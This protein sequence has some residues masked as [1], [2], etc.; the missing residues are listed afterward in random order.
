M[1]DLVNALRE[2]R[3]ILFVGAG[4]SR[5]LGLPSFDQ[6]IDHLA[7]ELG[8]DPEIFRLFGDYLSLAEYYNLQKRTLGPL[9]SWLDREWHTGIDIASSRIHELMVKL[10]CPLVYTTNYDRWIEIAHAHYGVAYKKVVNVGDMPNVDAS[11]V[12]IVKFHGDFD[13][14]NSIIL[15]ESSYFERLSFESPL[16]IKLRS[17]VLGRAVLFIGYSL[18]DINIRYMLYKLHRQWETS[19]YAKVRPKSYF[20]LSSPNPVHEQI[21]QERGILSFTSQED[22]PGKGLE[23]FLR[24]LVSRAF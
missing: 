16:D 22:D 11:S 9:R 15:T 23:A 7:K 18:S 17:D 6:L 20:F 13:D 10:K 14:D 1:D 19:G 5:N 4:V 21:L 24:E 12:Q 2:K 8:F 3:V